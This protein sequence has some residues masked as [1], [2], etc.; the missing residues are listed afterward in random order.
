MRNV[1]CAILVIMDLSANFA[2]LDT[3]HWTMVVAINVVVIPR[4][5]NLT[6]SMFVTLTVNVI[7]EQNSVVFNVSIA[8][9]P[10]WERA[11]TN[12]KLTI[13]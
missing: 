4:A 8:L 5:L 7:A 10:D 9:N 13:R 3:S 11:V 6:S 1:K 2:A 12:V